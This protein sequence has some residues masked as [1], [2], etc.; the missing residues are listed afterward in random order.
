VNGYEVQ[1]VWDYPVYRQGDIV[2][3]I[4]NADVNQTNISAKLAYYYDYDPLDLSNDSDIQA[5]RWFDGISVNDTGVGLFQFVLNQSNGINQL[6]FYNLTLIFGEDLQNETGVEYYTAPRSSTRFEVKINEQLLLDSTKENNLDGAANVNNA[7]AL[8]NDNWVITFWLFGGMTFL[9]FWCLFVVYW[10]SQK[11]ITIR[12][13]LWDKVM[14][15]YNK[16]NVP[17]GDLYPLINADNMQEL[18]MLGLEILGKQEKFLIKKRDFH[19]QKF[20]H[21]D[22]RLQRSFQDSGIMVSDLMEKNKDDPHLVWIL[23]QRSDST[24]ELGEGEVQFVPA[25]TKKY[26]VV[27]KV[28]K[29]EPTEV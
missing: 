7:I 17:V 13:F 25:K 9:F 28:I 24:I 26:K 20:E 14:T 16:I 19:K 6:G 5:V 11:D 21:F 22:H 23:K 8:S 4:V 15:V 2:Q 29:P 18:K 27:K 3:F 10:H 12:R 1:P